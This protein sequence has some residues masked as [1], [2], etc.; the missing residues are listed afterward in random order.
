VYLTL[1]LAFLSGSVVTGALAG[2]VFGLAR[3]A[4]LLAA[5][6]ARH[7]RDLHARQRRFAARARMATGTTLVGEAV[8]AG[9]AVLMA[10]RV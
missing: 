8:A 7:L 10:V 3:S 2:A 1:A 5:G 4:T 6:T 9:V